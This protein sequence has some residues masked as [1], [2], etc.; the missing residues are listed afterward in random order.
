LVFGVLEDKHYRP[1]VRMLLPYIKNVILT[2][3]VSKRAL[4]AERLIPL[5]K[6]QVKKHIRISIKKNPGEALET[7]KQWQREILITGSFYL[8]GEM[9]NIIM[10]GG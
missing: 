8:A 4:P 5:F 3:P 2:E 9:R 10:Q 1:M 6:K 7:A